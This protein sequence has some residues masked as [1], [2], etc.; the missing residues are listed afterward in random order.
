M[1]PGLSQSILKA[2]IAKPKV[3]VSYHRG[4]DLGYYQEFSRIFG[5]RYYLCYD[6]SVDA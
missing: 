1:S 5:D 4:R 6:N 3:F 2:L